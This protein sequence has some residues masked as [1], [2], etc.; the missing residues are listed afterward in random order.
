MESLFGDS[1]FWVNIGFY[2]FFRIF[3]KITVFL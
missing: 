2:N 3:A 1:F